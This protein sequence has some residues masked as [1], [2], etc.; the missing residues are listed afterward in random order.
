VPD[1]ASDPPQPTYLILVG[2]AS[3]CSGCHSPALFHSATTNH[4]GHRICAKVALKQRRASPSAYNSRNGPRWTSMTSPT[5]DG[6]ARRVNFSLPLLRAFSVDWRPRWR[7]GRGH[8]DTRARP[9]PDSR[10]NRAD[11]RRPDRRDRKSPPTSPP[12]APLLHPR[13][14]RKE[15]GPRR[16]RPSRTANR[17]APEAQ[18]SPRAKGSAQSAGSADRTTQQSKSLLP[19]WQASP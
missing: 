14:A 17:H 13:R 7:R 18:R 5:S 4:L 10:A 16:R 8:D 12:L 1:S 3:H 9:Y 6:Q 2:I 19:C 11:G 15:D